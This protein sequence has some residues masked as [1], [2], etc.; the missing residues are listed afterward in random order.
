MLEVGAGDCLREEEELRDGLDFEPRREDNALDAGLGV[1]LPEPDREEG[2]EA[3][4]DMGVEGRVEGRVEDSLRG[5]GA[6][7]DITLPLTIVFRH[8]CNEGGKGSGVEGRFEA[9]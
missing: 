1:D 9:F 5:L 6:L 2:L 7:G 3:L 8:G 4:R